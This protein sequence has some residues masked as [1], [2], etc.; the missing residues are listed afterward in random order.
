MTEHREDHLTDH[1]YDGIQEFDNPL[2]GWWKALFWGSFVFSLLYWGWFHVYPGKSIISDWEA[3]VE[4]ARSSG[5]ARFGE[6]SDTPETLLAL[7]AQPDARKIGATLFATKGCAACH[8][9]DGGGVVGLGANFCDDLAIN[10]T[11]LPGI[12][13]VVRSGVPGTAMVP[14]T[15]LLSPQEIY[16]V[17]AHVAGLRGTTPAKPRPLDPKAKEIAPWPTR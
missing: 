2:P 3:E 10:Y 5:Y 1:S 7:M 11:D 13:K 17:A 4:E 6:L 16:F 15:S 8:A 12:L 14:R 9:P